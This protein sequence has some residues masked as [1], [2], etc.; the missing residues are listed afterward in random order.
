MFIVLTIL[1]VIIWWGLRAPSER[2][3]L[4]QLEDDLV[5]MLAELEALQ[6]RIDSLQ[7]EDQPTPIR[8]TKLKVISGGKN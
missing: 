4:D 2:K 3:Q 7:G 8:G 1:C 6:A 5:D